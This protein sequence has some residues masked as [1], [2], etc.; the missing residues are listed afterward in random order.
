MVKPISGRLKRLW[1]LVDRQY[2][3]E[4]YPNGLIG[5]SRT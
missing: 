3:V 2:F 5:R 4:R 1:L